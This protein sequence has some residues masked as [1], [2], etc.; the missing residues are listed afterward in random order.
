MWIRRTLEE[1]SRSLAVAQQEA[2]FKGLMIGLAGWG[3]AVVL[4]SAGWVV[5]FSSGM[6]VHRSYG[7]S[8]WLR[9]VIF[10]VITSPIIFFARRVE[11]RRALQDLAR[12]IC[13]NCDTPATGNAGSPCPCGGEFVPA[14]SMK[15]VEE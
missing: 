11:S 12:T 7:G 8:F 4:G 9:L 3:I 2:R 14:S 1:E 13:P 5:S 10:G 15:W 6:A